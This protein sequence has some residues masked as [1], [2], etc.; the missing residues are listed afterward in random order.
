M[1]LNLA[2]LASVLGLSVSAL[3]A[4]IT[5]SYINTPESLGNVE[6][7]TSQTS[8]SYQIRLGYGSASDLQLS[9]ERQEDVIFLPSYS[10]YN[11]L[12]PN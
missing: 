11:Y 12:M 7:S 4:D 2:V 1:Y 9:P 10:Q 5:G 6:K 3:S 8:A